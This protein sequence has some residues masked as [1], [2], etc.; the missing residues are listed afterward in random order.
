MW[1]QDFTPTAFSMSIHVLLSP[2]RKAH[3]PATV[4]G[5][6]Y[7]CNIVAF[8][9]TKD[10]ICLYDIW[11]SRN[12]RISLETWNLHT[13]VI[14][15]QIINLQENIKHSATVSYG[16]MKNAKL[17][18]LGWR[19]YFFFVSPRYFHHKLR[20][21]YYLL[22]RRKIRQDCPFYH[23]LTYFNWKF[24]TVKCYTFLNY[25][26]QNDYYMFTTYFNR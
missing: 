12:S 3:N 17:M 7:L 4:E 13:K 6:H 10:K 11:C 1:Q 8:V 26:S 20:S 5:T 23:L 18:F 9:N 25:L 19:N 24:F 14:T 16:V 22:N 2:S 21:I 15:K